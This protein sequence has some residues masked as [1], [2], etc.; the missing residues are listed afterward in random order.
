MSNTTDKKLAKKGEMVVLSKGEGTWL[1]HLVLDGEVVWRIED[2]V[3]LW[4]PVSDT[5]SDGTKRLPSDMEYRPDIPHML[6][7]DWDAAEKEKVD[8][9]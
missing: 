9:E 4:T 1:S 5:F 8:M 7:K 3:P 2:D 6:V